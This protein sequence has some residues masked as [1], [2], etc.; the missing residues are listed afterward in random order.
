[1]DSTQAGPDQLIVEAELPADPPEDFSLN[2]Y[3]GCVLPEDYRPARSTTW[4][5]WCES[6]PDDYSEPQ[7]ALIREKLLSGRSWVC[8]VK[9][10]E[11]ISAPDHY[12]RR[13]PYNNPVQPKAKLP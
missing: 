3:K 7:L 12:I 2:V 5:K 13:E 10:L 6:N 4:N 1:M 11:T 9:R 8:F